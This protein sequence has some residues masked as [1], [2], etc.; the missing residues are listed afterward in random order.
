LDIG[1]LMPS[2]EIITIGTELLLGEIFDTNTR[3]LARAL[4]DAGIDL[5]RTTT[6]GDNINRIAQAIQE[7]L[8]RSEI[9][10]TTGGL[11]PTV[12]DPTRLAV[13]QAVGAPLE[14]RPDLWDQIQE[15]FRR[16]GRTPGENNRRQAYIPSGAIP[17]EN[18]V[19][20]APAFI[21]EVGKS[22]IACLPGV[23]KEMEYLLHNAILPYLKD[24]FQLKDIIKAMVMHTVSMGESMVDELIGD[25]ETLS[26]PTVGLLAHPGQTDIRVTAKAASVEEADRMIA[27]VAQDLRQRLGFTIYGVDQETLEQMTIAEVQK[28]GVRVSILEAGLNGSLIK[29]LVS[30][31]L[32]ASAGEMI[33][34]PLDSV[35]LF[36]HANLMHQNQGADLTIGA[37]LIPGDARQDLVMV[38]I[39][40]GASQEIK[41]SYGGPPLNAPSWA[42]NNGIDLLRRYLLEN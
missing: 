17:I 13:A 33:Q 23:P 26:N 1:E 28:K 37:S 2:A 39:T 9:I 5:Y 24:H 25:L 20:T 16:Y 40:P 42:V 15:R 6:V 19:G 31:G 11:G 7:A 29:R 14:Y 3:Y 12:D 27:E 38:L 32:P 22:S 30:A 8:T 34:N 10:I 41:R 36:Q 18:P 35:N 4:R 21:Y